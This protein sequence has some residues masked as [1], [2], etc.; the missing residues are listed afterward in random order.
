MC[1]EYTAVKINAC[2]SRRRPV[3]GSGIKPIRAKSIWHS[4]PGSPSATRTVVPRAAADSRSTLR[5]RTGATSGTAP[6]RPRRVSRSPILTTVRPWLDPLADLF[7]LG[8]QRLPRRRRDPPAVPGAPR[9]PP[10]RSARRSTA[11]PAVAAEP[12]RLRRLHIPAR[13]LAVDPRLPR[14]PSAA[15]APASQARS[16]SRTS[17]T[18]PPEHH[19][20]TSTSIDLEQSNRSNRGPPGA[21]RRVV[22]LL[23][24]RWSHDRGKTQLKWSHARGKRQSP[25]CVWTLG[26]RRSCAWR[27]GAPTNL[28]SC[29][30]RTAT[31]S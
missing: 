13:G 23:A 24:T 22:P 14:R 12:G 4:T 21:T 9:P 30:S 11:P 10:P 26:T 17:N 27:S 20:P 18:E 28:G 1:R 5:R 31:G 6:P 7:L 25:A 16:T 19:P 15:P 8:H 2:T 29:S 3:S